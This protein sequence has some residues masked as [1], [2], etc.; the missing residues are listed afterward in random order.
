MVSYFGGSLWGVGGGGL[1]FWC[2]ILQ[3]PKFK[4]FFD[5]LKFIPRNAVGGAC[6]NVQKFKTFWGDPAKTPRSRTLRKQTPLTKDYGT[7]PADAEKECVRRRRHIL[8][9]PLPWPPPGSGHGNYYLCDMGT[10]F[11]T[12]SHVTSLTRHTSLSHTVACEREG[13]Y[14]WRS[15]RGLSR[16]PTKVQSLR[17]RKRSDFRFSAATTRSEAFQECSNGRSLQCCRENFSASGTFL[18]SC[19]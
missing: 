3:S 7:F 9:T 16:W 5:V 13:L 15:R 6:S 2:L 19:H 4:Y 12:F 11:R 17:R 18:A 14:T 10:S 1:I 8:C